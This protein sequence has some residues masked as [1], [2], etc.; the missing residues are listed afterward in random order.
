MQAQLPGVALFRLLLA[1]M[2]V[3]VTVLATTPLDEL[4]P[5]PLNDK[6]G[7]MSA[8][9]GLALLTDFSFRRS[10][11]DLNKALPLLGYG[12]LVEV[13]QLFVPYRDFSLLDLGA[14]ALGLAAYGASVP[15]LRRMPVLSE[16]WA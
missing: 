12:L 16:R 4:P 11:L 14:D 2:L 9:Y 8:F 15:L 13:V 10:G 7:H 5:L 6:L 3:A 1:V